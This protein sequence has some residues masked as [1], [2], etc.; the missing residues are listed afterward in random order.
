MPVYARHAMCPLETFS[1]V[2]NGNWRLL[3]KFPNN[4]GVHVGNAYSSSDIFGNAQIIVETCWVHFSLFFPR[5]SYW[6]REEGKS[7][8]KKILLIGNKES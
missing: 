7:A 1:P 4:I 5:Y 3:G 2:P 6:L 8:E